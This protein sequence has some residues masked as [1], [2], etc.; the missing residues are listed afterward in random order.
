MNAPVYYMLH[1]LPV[2]LL[3]GVVFFLV[4]IWLG[5]ML[6]KNTSEQAEQFRAEIKEY[7]RKAAALYAKTSEPGPK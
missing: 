4:G 5:S 3:L 7:E 6:W 2:V 1:A